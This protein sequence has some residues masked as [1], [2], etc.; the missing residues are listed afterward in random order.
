MVAKQV[1]AAGLIVVA[2]ANVVLAG[3]LN[4]RAQRQVSVEGQQHLGIISFFPYLAQ[5][6]WY[7]P[8]GWALQR[9]YRGHLVAAVILFLFGGFLLL[10]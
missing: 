9:R 10:S 7:T 2:F 1:V 4:F 3:V 8:T 5:Q 6:G